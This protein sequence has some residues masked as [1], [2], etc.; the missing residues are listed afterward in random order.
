MLYTMHDKLRDIPPEKLTKAQAKNELENLASEIAKHDEYYYN[1]NMPEISDAEYDVLRKR[2]DA[3]ENLFPDLIRKDSPSH[4][5]GSKPNT[6]FSKIAHS[7]P[8]LS[9]ANAFEREDIADFITRIKRFL[10]LPDEE[11]IQVLA[12][13]KIDGLS[14]SARYENGVLVQGATRG[15]GT[16]GEDITKNLAT[17]KTL[18]SHIKSHN[19]PEIL[20]VRGE[21]Y[22]SHQDFILLNTTREKQEETLF[23]N[24]R[25]AAAGSLRQ[26][27]P[28]ITAQR[29]LRYF[30]YA[31]GELSHPIGQ[32]QSEI[33]ASLNSF[34]F[35]TNDNSK[36]CNNIDQILQFYEMLYSKRPN[37][38]YDID[39]VVYKVNRLDWQQRLGTISRSPRWAI[40]HKFPAEQAKTILEKITI[41]VGRTGALTPVANL[42]P[43][44]VGGV[45]VSRATLHNEDEIVSKDIREGDLV[46][47][48]RAGD[49]IPQIV[50]VDLSAR[51]AGAQHF[52]FPDHC[53]VCGSVAVREEGEAVKRCTGGLVCHAQVIEK[54][55][56]FVS[57]NAFDIEGLGDKQIDSFWH[58]EIVQKPVDIFYLEERDKASLNKL[59]NREG[60][61]RLSV[62][63]LFSAINQK[64]K[65]SLE[66][67]IYALGIRHIGQATAKL[68]AQNYSSWQNFIA[69]MEAATNKSTDAYT[70]LLSIEGI[71][72][73]VAQSI[74]DFF[75]EVNNLNALSE[76]VAQ[77]EIIDA[78][79]PLANSPISDKTIVFTG[80]LEKMSRHEAKARAESLGAKVAGSI[81]AKTDYLIAGADSG[82]KLKKAQEL[83][84]KVLT[85]A[86][87]LE[88]SG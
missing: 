63:N 66:R 85:E 38:D 67:F 35:S 16:T 4:K 27:D 5:V 22:M 9:L 59:E 87:W 84:V 8:M 76:L 45:V 25:N 1:N 13:P 64:R 41:Q 53:P 70:E 88:L 31:V 6:K 80:T 42:T 2:N 37:L 56:H 48:Q 62:T 57:K 21:V 34:G 23:A 55:K 11:D 20:E 15:D 28:D 50:S 60:W 7:Q 75:S 24:P 36:V 51:K 17:I 77:L 78:K 43:V 19:V 82:S 18:P 83:G 54:L 33:M 12:E 32:L 79:K 52:K 74:I 68:L 71:G 3:I 65:I 49:V 10:A 44:N 86:E 47:I 46:V 40:A 73:V 30:V 39:G 69:C 29:N 14:F 81:S 58:D 61:G 26:L 72:E